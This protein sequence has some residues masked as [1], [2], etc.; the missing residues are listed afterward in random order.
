MKA[1][2][3]AHQKFIHEAP[4]KLRLIA[5]AIR[6]QNVKS[7]MET[8]TFSSKHAAETMKK[9]LTQAK[10]NAVNNGG[11]IEDGLVVKA[12]VVDEGPRIKR[13]RPVARGMA[14]SVI[15]RTSHVKITV[16]GNKPEIKQAS[17][18]KKEG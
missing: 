1:Q 18:K 10:A 11:V 4:R 8:L 17:D 15:K 6:G 3:T 16:E 9:I 14:H 5:D 13:W 2:A 7:A 12:V